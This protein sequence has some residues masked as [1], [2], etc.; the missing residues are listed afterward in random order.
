MADK[1]SPSEIDTF[2]DITT[3][4]TEYD[5]GLASFNEIVKRST[6][7]LNDHGGRD[8]QSYRGTLIELN[9][10]W[11]HLDQTATLSGRLYLMDEAYVTLAPE[12]WEG[13]FEDEKGTYF[14]V[15]NAELTSLGVI[16][17]LA[18]RPGK[19]DDEGEIFNPVML[20][21][22][23][24]PEDIESDDAI[25]CATPEDI[26]ACRYDLPTSEATAYRL[27]YHWPKQMKKLDRRMDKAGIDPM[28]Q[29]TYLEKSIKTLQES[30]RASEDLRL[31]LPRYLHE[32]LDLDIRWP[33][34]VTLVGSAYIQKPGEALMPVEFTNVSTQFLKV[35]GIAL[36]FDEKD[37]TEDIEICIVFASP[38]SQVDGEDLDV[39]LSAP[40]KSIQNMFPTRPMGS[41]SEILE[42]TDTPS[43][44]AHVADL[45]LPK[46]AEIRLLDDF[47]AE[48]VLHPRIAE[49]RR[50][51]KLHNLLDEMTEET[52]RLRKTR[53]KN[54]E[55]AMELSQ[56]LS[57]NYFQKMTDLNLE[58]SDV[59]QAA[60]IGILKANANLKTAL[61]AV[62]VNQDNE[63]PIISPSIATDVI[64]SYEAFLAEVD[65]YKDEDDTAYWQIAPK[66]IL[67]TRDTRVNMTGQAF[68][69]PLLSVAVK[70][71]VAAR[72][73]DSVNFT[74]PEYDR[75]KARNEAMLRLVLSR[76]REVN[77]KKLKAVHEAFMHESPDSFVRAKASVSH[78]RRI[79]QSLHEHP[80]VDLMEAFRHQLMHRKVEIIADAWVGTKVIEQA[81]VTGTIIDVYETEIAG[82]KEIVAA[83][84]SDTS[85]NDAVRDTEPAQL[86]VL[87]TLSH[88][89]F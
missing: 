43:N 9:D 1:L 11:E 18:D 44:H 23:F 64:G 77:T 27:H 25:F 54:K 65:E 74:V 86:M 51:E 52:N 73:D 28:R 58:S 89:Q 36:S 24:V 61:G 12:E 34:G 7:F 57:R 63:T 67:C 53:F 15:E 81:A 49:F 78:I 87:R 22:G 47:E 35:S 29:I 83:L 50:L 41:I 26:L 55:A 31:W 3:G 5:H 30:L 72:L 66:I 56:M 42:G 60:G 37:S 45:P 69:Y 71:S 79:S 4:F 68:N 80:D 2:Y 39:Y 75:A 14:R 84:A 6:V 10:N 59:I 32:R 40:L 38:T 85:L 20:A 48:E 21:H 62:Q 88:L 46:D 13:P 33:Y 17:A 16:D 82:G 76:R 8:S 70:S 19:V